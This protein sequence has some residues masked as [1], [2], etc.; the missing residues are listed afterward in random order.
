MPTPYPLTF[1]ALSLFN[2]AL[3]THTHLR[4]RAAP[5]RHSKPSPP[6]GEEES[7][8]LASLLDSQT[9]SSKLEQGKKEEHDDDD[10][11]NEKKYPV[12]PHA[13]RDF[14]RRYFPVYILAMAADWLQVRPHLLALAL[15]PDFAPPFPLTHQ[16]GPYIYTLYTQTKH[17]STRTTAHLFTT[18]FLSAALSAAPLG[19]LTQYH[20][21]RAGCLFYCLTAFLACL[22]VFSESLPILYAGRVAGGW[23]TTGLFS[24]FEAWMVEEFRRRGLGAGGGGGLERMFEVSVLGS[25]V[26]AIVA[27]VVGEVVVEGSGRRESVFAV[28]AGCC[29]L[30]AGGILG[31]WQTPPS[32]SSSS[33]SSTPLNSPTLLALTFTTTAFEGSMYLFVVFWTPFLKTAHNPP[34]PTKPSNTSS[35]SSPEENLP[36]G[37]V[38]ATLMTTLMLGSQVPGLLPR[39]RSKRKNKTRTKSMPYSAHLLPPTLA[40]AA[41]ALLLPTLFPQSPGTVFWSFALFEACVGVYYP[42]VMGVRK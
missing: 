9:S 34:K 28:A 25:G 32:S 27:G 24:A 36:L 18:G 23:A 38:F 10:D 21:N 31:F 16:Q 4:S 15:P 11:R 6:N 37:L 30:A 22:S 39:I 33:S 5:Q 13:L 42:T 1:T 26:T 29:V 2:L 12:D 3:L 35:S 8:G 19:Y 7:V 40:L 14:Q 41:I 20:G 17:L